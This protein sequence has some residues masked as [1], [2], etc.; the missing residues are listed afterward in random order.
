MSV[1]EGREVE[2]FSKVEGFKRDS[3]GLRGSI[4][5]ELSQPV[6]A[7]TEEAAQLLKHHGTYQQDNRDTRTERKKA[8]LGRDF[9]FMVR[10]KF[11][12]GRLTA[13]QYLICDKLA[14]RYGQGD[15]RVTSRQCFQLHGVLKKNLRSLIHDLNHYA[16]ITS[17]GACGDVVRNV[18]ASPVSDIDP[19]F[20][21]VGADLGKL[22]K[23]ISDCFLPK[24]RGYYD[25]W[26][27]DERVAVNEDGTVDFLKEEPAEGEED[28]IYGNRY[29][30]RK[31]KIAL[32]PDF[33]NSVDVYANDIAIVA[34]TEEGRLAG[35]EIAVG[36]GLGFTHRKESTYPRLATPLAFVQEE[37]ILPIVEAIVRVQRD[38]GDRVNRRHARMKY[39]IDDLG[40]DAFRARVFE[41]AGRSYPPPRGIK[42]SA[43]PDYLGWSR[44]RQPGLNYVGLW[45]EN[46]RIRDFPGSFQFRTG[47][48]RIV[49]QF[50]PDLR[51]TPHHNVILA[52]IRDEDAA[53]IQALLDEYRIP[54]DTGISTLRR[55]EM[56]C[57]ALPS[58][59]LALAEAERFL[60]SVVTDLERAGHGDAELVLRMN[61]CPNNC[62]RSITAELGVI[63]CGSGLYTIYTGGGHTGARLG[64]TF[65]DRVPAGEVSDVLS[66]LLTVWKE[67]RH[68]DERFGDWSFRVGTDELKEK[69]QRAVN[70]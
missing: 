14:D 36:G 40:I 22:A 32:A 26:I 16:N 37:E 52:N 65:L 46:G 35:Y 24:T 31:F 23:Q 17:L 20:A 58:C 44:Q 18:I 39:L 38:F 21:A 66:A 34:V 43:Q 3:R 64:Q 48:R 4:A 68:R 70:G 47:L 55:M 29:L 27:N 45:I 53:A 12:G 7:F 61:G 50:N 19:K 67:E 57:P 63:G 10:T 69:I 59:G 54:T 33:D 9:C 5:A 6:T 30:P 42:P 28:P 1:N 49:E 25:L 56:A 2:T 11:P 13:E 8:G 41:Y 51:L 62:A 15:L 60:P